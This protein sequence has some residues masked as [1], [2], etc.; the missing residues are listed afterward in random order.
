MRAKE[1]REPLDTEK[2]LKRRIPF[3][4][5]LNTSQTALALQPSLIN[6]CE[7]E[8]GWAGLGESLLFALFLIH[9]LHFHPPVL[10]PDFDLSLTQ[11]EESGHFVPTVPGE[12][13]I[14]QKLL[15]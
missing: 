13:H 5:H 3:P 11:I 9:F 10:K 14:E 8:K 15:L 1:R 6:K 4:I 7:M 2:D 12:V